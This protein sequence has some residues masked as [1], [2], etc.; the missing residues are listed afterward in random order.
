ML[1]ILSALGLT[2]WRLVMAMVPV[3]AV[4]LVP[5][6]MI[7][8]PCSIVQFG[9]EPSLLMAAIARLL[10]VAREV[11]ERNFSPNSTQLESKRIRHYY[12]YTRQIHNC[13]YRVIVKSAMPPKA[14]SPSFTKV[15]KAIKLL[16]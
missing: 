5:V 9:T 7:D 14:T 2:P 8:L 15:N 11:E 4:P 12:H 10:L 13:C 6:I 16:Q 3:A 1:T